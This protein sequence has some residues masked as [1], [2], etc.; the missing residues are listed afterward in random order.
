MNQIDCAPSK[1]IQMHSFNT[2]NEPNKICL[3]AK[4]FMSPLT[5]FPFIII[6]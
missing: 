2:M 5:L 3:Q 4:F 6:F 1:S